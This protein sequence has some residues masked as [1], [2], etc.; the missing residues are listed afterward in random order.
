M[1]RFK[2][3]VRLLFSILVVSIGIHA[4]H[5]DPYFEPHRT[6]IVHLF[7]WKF[8]DI[9]KECTEYLGPNGF[10]AVQVSPVHENVVSSTRSWWERYQPISY[11]IAT[12][13]GNE[14]EFADM[15]AECERAG[16]RI[17]VDVVPNHMTA[18]RGNITGTGGSTADVD[19]RSYPAVPYT[20][21]HFHPPC[22]ISNY[23][24]ASEVRNCEL[25]GLPDLN[26]THPYVRSKIV[27]FMNRCIDH[28]VGG[29]RV[30]AAKH[31]WPKD[32]REMYS[33]LHDLKSN[34]RHIPLNA[35]PFIYQEVIDLGGEGVHE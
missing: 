19:K 13:S 34:I 21:E 14:K 22:A 30:D 33:Q 7:E 27:E 12:R 5:I 1:F 18:M 29:F 25:V 10:A 23:Q 6:G 16:I 3:E 11:K 32:L 9:A 8:S 2:S 17:Y 35:K 24:N 28:G 26:Q 31:M 15:V 4:D 20:S